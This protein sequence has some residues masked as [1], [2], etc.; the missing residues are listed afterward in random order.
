MQKVCYFI[1]NIGYYGLVFD[2]YIYFIFFIWCFLDMMVYWLVIRYMDGGCSVLEMKYEDLCDYSLNMEQ[3]VVNVECVFI[4][5]KQVEFMSE[6]LGQIYDGVIFGVIEWGLYVELNENKCEGMIFIC[7]LDDD[8]YEFDE[9][10]YCLCGCC[11]NCIYSLGDVII[12][13]VVCVN[14]EKK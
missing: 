11:K 5:Y 13:K 7:D 1:Y 3:I 6:W 14:L 12:V 9:K 10:N 8:Y 2:Y 4:K